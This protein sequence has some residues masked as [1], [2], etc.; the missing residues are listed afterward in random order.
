MAIATRIIMRRF[1]NAIKRL[2]SKLG[3]GRGHLDFSCYTERIK[4][5]WKTT[6]LETVFLRTFPWNNG[7]AWF[8][9][10]PRPSFFAIERLRECDTRS[11]RY[12]D[13]QESFMD[14]IRAI[15]T[16]FHRPSPSTFFWRK[17][18][19][20]SLISDREDNDLTRNRFFRVIW[21]V[22][23]IFFFPW[24][25]GARSRDILTEGGREGVDDRCRMTRT[26][27]L[28]IFISRRRKINGVGAFSMA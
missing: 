5:S 10:L 26:V 23:L 20:R 27:I 9:M 17:I 24:N 14:R 12:N 18:S 1:F 6:F 25:L 2:G 21:F 19:W 8:R 3:R 16:L 11:R 13:K 22:W 4:R 28:K 7:T 15:A